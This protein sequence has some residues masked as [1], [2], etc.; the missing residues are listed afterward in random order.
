MDRRERKKKP[1]QRTRVR[2]QGDRNP[3]NEPVVGVLRPMLRRP[4]RQHGAIAARGRG[5]KDDNDAKFR[6]HIDGRE[7]RSPPRRG[8]D[9]ADDPRR[10]TPRSATVL[11]PRASAPGIAIGRR[12]TLQNRRKETGG[13]P[14]K[15]RFGGWGA[16]GTKGRTSIVT[17]TPTRAENG[18]ARSGRPG[19]RN[20]SPRIADSPRRLRRLTRPDARF[21]IRRQ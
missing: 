16:G 5:A 1:G 18:L 6:S 3:R 9:A 7:Y 10:K 21:G 19:G 2:G 15:S 14:R 13:G 4:R 8:R 20:T 11:A 12:A 17:T